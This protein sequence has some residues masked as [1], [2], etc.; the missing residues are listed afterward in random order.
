L[1]AHQGILLASRGRRPCLF[2]VKPIKV[3]EI[4]SK[5]EKFG[6]S[7]VIAFGLHGAVSLDAGDP[8]GRNYC[9]HGSEE[10]SKWT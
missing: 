5:D 1:D 10:Q 6:W 4:W 3:K 8:I 9:R 2:A 7:Q